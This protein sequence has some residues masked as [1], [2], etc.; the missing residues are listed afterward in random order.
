VRKGLLLAR[1]VA[2]ALASPGLARLPPRRLAGVLQMRS[3]GEARDASA[4]AAAERALAITARLI[5]HTCYT[6]GITRYL[7]LRRGRSDVALVFGIDAS[8]PVHDGHC[9][10]VLDGGPYLEP[11]DPA[12]RFVPVWRVGSG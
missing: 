12:H 2:V 9:W 4:P 6:R 8:S 7:L 11:E 1:S 10:I 3:G 5:R